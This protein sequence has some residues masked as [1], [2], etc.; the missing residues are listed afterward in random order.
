M[1]GRRSILHSKVEPAWLDLKAN[2][3][4]NRFAFVRIFFFGVLVIVV[5]GGIEAKAALTERASVIVTVQRTPVPEQVP[6]QPVK[7]EPAAGA[8]TRITGVPSS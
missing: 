3:T 5:P 1:N 2:L 7:V 4:V 6:L 8:A